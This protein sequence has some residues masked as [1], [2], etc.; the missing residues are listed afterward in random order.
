[1]AR[2]R[3]RRPRS[4]LVEF[5]L[6]AQIARTAPE[7]SSGPGTIAI[8]RR[9]SDYHYWRRGPMAAF[10]CHLTAKRG[11][12]RRIVYNTVADEQ[13]QQPRPGLS[14]VVTGNFSTRIAALCVFRTKLYFACIIIVNNT[15]NKLKLRH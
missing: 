11:A 14:Y 10:L 15:I 3:A 1:M 13:A 5:T 2:A 12:A 8:A 6:I 7:R 9:A 4:S